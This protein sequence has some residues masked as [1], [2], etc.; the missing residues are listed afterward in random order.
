MTMKGRGA[1]VSPANCREHSVF[2][3]RRFFSDINGDGTARTVCKLAE[4]FFETA[5]TE[6]RA[7][8]VSNDAFD[9]D[10]VV[11]NGVGRVRKM[12]TTRLDLG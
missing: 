11:E 1:V 9:W 8:L 2:G 5:L 10:L 12:S 6:R 3:S 7:L 4:A